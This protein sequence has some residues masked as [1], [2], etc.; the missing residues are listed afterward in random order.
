ML[1]R[2]AQKITHQ[3]SDTFHVT[4]SED[5]TDYLVMHL[6]ANQTWKEIDEHQT[7]EEVRQAVTQFLQHIE[8][9]SGHRFVDDDIL[10]QD[11]MPHMKP[12]LNRIQYGVSLQN[13][14][15]H[16]I[17]TSYPYPFD[18]AVSG[19][20]ALQLVRTPNEDEAAYVALHIAASFERSHLDT[21]QKRGPL[22][23]AGLD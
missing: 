3:I 5:E 13:P 11:L 20:N 6:L 19:L 2:I 10:R 15:L 8:K 12:L 21:S 9:T 17:K 16:E 1:T 4:L 14:L 23:Y 22:L 18:L 7:T